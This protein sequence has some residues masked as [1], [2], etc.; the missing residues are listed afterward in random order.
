MAADQRWSHLSD[1]HIVESEGDWL[2]GEL[3]SVEG[4]I[5]VEGH[6]LGV[7][8]VEGGDDTNDYAV[9]VVAGSA[10]PV[11]SVELLI[12]GGDIEWVDLGVSAIVD[13]SEVSLGHWL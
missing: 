10:V 12:T 1:Y 9:A 11:L 8:V 2:P 4:D 5:D 13:G 3:L 7:E 6:V